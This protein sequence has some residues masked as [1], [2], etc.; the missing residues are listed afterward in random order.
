MSVIVKDLIKRYYQVDLN[1]RLDL[2][3]AIQELSK[4]GIIDADGIVILNM[5]MEGV[6]NSKIVD[7]IGVS[8]STINRK[9]N[10]ISNRIALY[11]GGTYDDSRILLTVEEK[12]GRPLTDE[13]VS[14]CWF[15]IKFY[16]RDINR[17]L[18]IYNFKAD[19]KG[20]FVPRTEDKTEG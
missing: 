16:G 9:L 12:L 1:T 19:G 2:D 10:D 7:T 5:V 20:K 13:E 8:V 4:Q 15:M 6:E 14:F 3:V 17:D 11:L 18:S